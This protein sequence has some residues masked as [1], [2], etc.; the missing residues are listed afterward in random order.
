MTTS[1]DVTQAA[2]L[3]GGLGLRLRPAVP[4]LPKVLAP[5]AGRPFLAHVLDRLRLH[6][7]RRV[8]LCVGYRA[9]EIAAYFRDGSDFGLDI[10]Y[11]LEDAPLGT[12]GA[13]R[14]A[15][16]FLDHTF[17]LLNGDTLVDLNFAEL[18][19][20]HRARGGLVTVVGRKSR[21]RPRH[22]AG[23]VLTGRGGKV[24]AFAR[25]ALP[26]PAGAAAIAEAWVCCGWFMCERRMFEAAALVAPG[27]A[28]GGGTRTGPYSLEAGLLV[29]LLGSVY[30]YP[31]TG[32]FTDIGTP[33]RYRQL[34][35]EWERK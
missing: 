27:E 23:Y 18:T 28:P 32:R 7:I 2:V 5:V 6:G 21:G 11:S 14:L 16:R 34:K 9:E 12:G 8:V 19:R 15:Q 17:L 13:V 4:D 35:G 3:A 20:Y 29:P 26:H 30:V 22:D 24:T 33:D 31:S 1:S 25:G 10:R